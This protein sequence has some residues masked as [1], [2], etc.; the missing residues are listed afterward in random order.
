MNMHTQTQPERALTEKKWKKKASKSIIIHT[1]WPHLYLKQKIKPIQ[2]IYKCT[3]SATCIGIYVCIHN[4]W[5]EGDIP[6]SLWKEVSWEKWKGTFSFAFYLNLFYSNMH[7]LVSYFFL[8]YK[9]AKWADYMLM[10]SSMFNV[11]MAL[12]FARYLGSQVLPS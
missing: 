7:S 12:H 2:N 5:C 4:K 9:K 8:C 10:M 1:P 6:L 11:L 3:P